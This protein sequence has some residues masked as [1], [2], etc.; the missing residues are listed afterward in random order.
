LTFQFRCPIFAHVGRGVKLSVSATRF[1]SGR[2]IICAG[3]FMIREFGKGA[4]SAPAPERSLSPEKNHA[5]RNENLSPGSFHTAKDQ[6]DEDGDN[7]L[8]I[9]SGILAGLLIIGGGIY[10]YESMHRA[11][12]PQQVALKTPAANPMA[13]D[14]AATPPA[15]TP[16]SAAPAMT[17]PPQPAPAAP[18][19]RRSRAVKA[20]DDSAASSATASAGRAIN[21]PMTLTPDTAL[22]PQQSVPGSVPAGQ[23]AMQPPLSAPDVSGQ[24]AQPMPAIANNDAPAA[25]SGP[26]PLQ[27]QL[28][29]PDQAQPQQQPTQ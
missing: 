3:G 29:A 18:A 23:T 28:P 26:Q 4:E 13:A 12:A 20:G 21:A 7:T 2:K 19:P 14:Q 6:D 10:A 9:A 16:D 8:T 25:P 11:T 17:A 1:P 22:A 24:N 27:P 5:G 15:A